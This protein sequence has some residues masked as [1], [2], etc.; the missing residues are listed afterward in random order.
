M[1]F[2]GIARDYRNISLKEKKTMHIWVSLELRGNI[3]NQEVSEKINNP[4]T[5]QAWKTGFSKYNPITLL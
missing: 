4:I 5:L 3:Q 1:N 2:G